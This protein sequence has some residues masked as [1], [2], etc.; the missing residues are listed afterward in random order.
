MHKSVRITVIS[1]PTAGK[2]GDGFVK[3]VLRGLIAR[4]DK[5][6]L[7]VTSHSGHANE[8]ARACAHEDTAD[9]I[10]AAG[11]DGTVREVA[12]GLIGT[13]IPI[14]I[15]PAGTANVLARELGYLVKGRHCIERTT[16]IIAQG[17]AID[18][19]PF[20]V[21]LPDRRG[22]PT[23]G[24]GPQFIGMCW[25]GAGLDAEVLKQVDYDL[26]SKYGRAAFVPAILKTLFREPRSPSVPW[27]I[28]ERPSQNVA[29][30]E[31]PEIVPETAPEAVPEAGMCGWGLVSN[32][33]GYA[34]PFTVTRHTQLC[35]PGLACL[36]FEK[37]GWPARVGDQIKMAFG[38]LDAR[39]GTRLIKA[40]SITMGDS[41]TPVQIDGDY[42]GTGP[43]TVEPMA[44]ILKFKTASTV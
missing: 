3:A 35:E 34:G 1:N 21:K 25:V 12:E 18:V 39:G 6:V 33:A 22:R 15:I 20:K 43:I 8:L 24:A 40:G 31:T 28:E 26:K 30:N 16:D 9:L 17:R 37:A 4:G 11:G 7:S 36:L 41:G 27:T 44:A 19:F 32:I 5:V 23:A 42:V 29:P 2:R 14:G 38:P 10:V 13:N